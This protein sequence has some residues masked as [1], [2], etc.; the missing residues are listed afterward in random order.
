LYTVK[1]TFGDGGGSPEERSVPSG[2]ERAEPIFIRKK[3]K[4]VGTSKPAVFFLLW[5]PMKAWEDRSLW[6]TDHTEFTD[7]RRSYR[8]ISGSR[9][10]SACAARCLNYERSELI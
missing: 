9:G 10:A 2:S 6:N 4:T 5:L 7:F 3:H 1:I 8:E